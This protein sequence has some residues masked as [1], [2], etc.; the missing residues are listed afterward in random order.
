MKIHPVSIQDIGLLEKLVL[1]QL[2]TFSGSVE[3]IE[4]GLSTEYGPLSLGIDRW[5]RPVLFVTSLS[6]DEGL[7]VKATA[8]AGWIVRYHSLVSRLFRPRELDF[9]KPPRII[10]LAPSYS[11]ASREAASALKMEIELYQYRVV[12]FRQERGILLD[13]VAVP[14]SKPSPVANPTA[15][16]AAEFPPPRDLPPS[17]ELTDSERQFF[18][19]SPSGNR[20]SQ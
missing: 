2:E 17:V 1:E 9:S 16:N 5:G 15:A 11:K 6:E 13:P 7:I 18:E 8:Q 14:E 3:L 10:L 20:A 4:Q 19:G 12:E